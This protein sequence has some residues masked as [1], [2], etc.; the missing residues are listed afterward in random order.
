M[1]PG[2]RAA[3]VAAAAG[4]AL[5]L[6]PAA[7]AQAGCFRTDYVALGDSYS[8]GTGAGS[9]IDEEC[10]R[11]EV[12]YP[13]LLE[14][15]L[16]GSFD[17]AACSGAETEDLLAN[18]LGELNW[19][20][21]LVT[22]GIGGNDIGWGNAVGACLQPESFDC[23]PV[24]ESA[25]AAIENELPALLDGVY[26]EIEERAWRAD[27]YVVGYPRLFSGEATCA[28]A[29]NVTVEEQVRMNEG[30]DVLSAVIEAK[31]EEYGFTYV[32]VRDVF[33]GHAICDE[34]PW[35]LGY[36]GGVESF[37]PDAE[38]QAAY[39]AALTEAL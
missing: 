24:I 36:T 15:D 1:K 35:L 29:P 31:A 19:R 18:Q 10:L 23:T 26:S 37:H 38:G 22:V 25:E 7:S 28:S 33:E 8:S 14:Q 5:L 3:T 6:F 20:T 16:R 17:F 11:S 12:A 27:V 4:A 2:K 21:D 39:Y 13:S 30:A 32:D 34:E 9:Y